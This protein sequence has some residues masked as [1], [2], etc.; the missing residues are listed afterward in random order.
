MLFLDFL[1]C[2][3][4]YYFVLPFSAIV[5]FN[6]YAKSVYDSEGIKNELSLFKAQGGSRFKIIEIAIWSKYLIK[7]PTKFP[8][9]MKLTHLT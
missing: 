5:H 8:T 2:F 4:I 9:L 3:Q 1:I 7:F 6:S